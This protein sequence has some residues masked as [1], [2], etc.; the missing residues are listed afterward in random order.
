MTVYDM[1]EGY[2]LTPA[3]A[4][5]ILALQDWLDHNEQLLEAKENGEICSDCQGTGLVTVGDPKSDDFREVECV[6]VKEAY[7]EHEANN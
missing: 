5:E 3:V 2:E 7:N 4:R 1:E 6:C